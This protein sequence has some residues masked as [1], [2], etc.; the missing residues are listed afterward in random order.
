LGGDYY[1]YV[2]LPGNRLAIVVADVAGKGIPAALL[3]AKLSADVRYCLAAERDV[4]KALKCINGAFA[5]AGWQ[6]RF[7]TCAVAV[8]DREQHEA[9]IVNAGHLPPLW[10]R[11]DGSVTPIGE[12]ETGIPLGI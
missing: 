8:L 11:I 10:R 2:E 12:A 3:M 6:D 7:V 9:T 1:D 4:A 5:S